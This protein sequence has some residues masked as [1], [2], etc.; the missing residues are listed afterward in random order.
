MINEAMEYLNTVL[1]ES[2]TEPELDTPEFR[3]NEMKTYL[4]NKFNGLMDTD[5]SGFDF[6]SDVA[7]WKLANDYHSGMSS[8]GYGILSTLPVKNGPTDRDM[9]EGGEWESTKMMYDALIEAGYQE[10]M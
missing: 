1:N 5:D 7:I 8:V 2:D 3:I 9:E 4:K 10:K 6:D